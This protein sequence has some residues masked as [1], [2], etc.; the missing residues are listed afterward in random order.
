[1][2]TALLRFI[3]ELRTAGL[4]ISIAESMDAMEA[5]GAVG[6]EQDLLR[7]AL[8][9]SLVKEE[10]DRFTF[11]EIFTRFFS[12]PRGQRKGKLQTSSGEGE[13]QHTKTQ[14]NLG[15]PQEQPPEQQHTTKSQVAKPSEQRPNNKGQETKSNESTS[16]SELRTSK[17]VLRPLA[18]E[19]RP[20]S[21]ELQVL[22][23]S[24]QPPVPRHKTL[25]EKPFRLFDAHDVEET[26]ELVEALARQ[27]RA[28]LSRRYKP[29]KHGRLDFRRTIRASISHGGVPID[30]FLRDRRPGKPDLVVLCDLS[31]SVATVTD[32]LLALIAPAS[33]YFRRVRMFAYVDRLCE[34]SFENGHVVPHTELDLYARSDFGKVLQRFW[35][36]GGEQMLN[37]QT[38]VLVL[39][40]A[41]NNRRPPRPDL[42]LRIRDSAKKLVWLNPEPLVR[43]NT[44]DSVM[45]LYEPACD[46]ILACG[47]L[48][49]LFIALKQAL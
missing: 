1:M 21:P 29:R 4:R 35:Q 11:D 5:V 34:V 40:D 28:R 45:K 19:P 48:Q 10:D 33:S 7:E 43:W 49:E 26:K 36:Q 46:M 23:P 6:L 14:G 31:G 39:G 41:R 15:R 13:R 42:L 3:T 22:A 32:F 18:S 16:N 12:R 38:L 20:L 27:L 9:T 47:N 44:G 24:L 17:S 2:R 30:L 25:L 8:A 37:Q